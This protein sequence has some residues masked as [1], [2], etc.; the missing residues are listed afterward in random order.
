MNIRTSGGFPASSTI[1][2]Y[3]SQDANDKLLGIFKDVYLISFLRHFRIEDWS[4]QTDLDA[5]SRNAVLF[6]EVTV[7]KKS[8][9]NIKMSLFELQANGGALIGSSETDT[10][11]GNATIKLTLPVLNPKKWTAETP[12]M[13]LVKFTLSSQSAATYTTQQRIGFRK[14][15]DTNN[16]LL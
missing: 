4:I 1:T 11:P 3:L 16:S 2:T 15:E 7:L 12:Y 13:Y 6:S 14:A 9:A 10:G 8:R 5:Q